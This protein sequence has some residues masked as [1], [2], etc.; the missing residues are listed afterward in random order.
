[1]LVVGTD[2][3]NR[4][5]LEQ[6]SDVAKE[7]G[8]QW[9]QDRFTQE[10]SGAG[11]DDHQGLVGGLKQR[12][13]EWGEVDGASLLLNL[14][15]GT[16]LGF[17]AI[18]S[19]IATL[20]V[21]ESSRIPPI[22]N[23]HSIT[24]RLVQDNSNGNGLA[25]VSNPF[26]SRYQDPVSKEVKEGTFAYK[27]EFRLQTQVGSSHH[28]LHLYV[29][30]RRY[31]D[32]PIVDVN[33]RRDVSVSVG[34]E[35]PRLTGWCHSST[36]VTLPLTGGPKNPRWLDDPALLLSAVQARRLVSPDIGRAHV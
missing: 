23:G 3:S 22:I 17:H 8:N 33:W 6:I 4:P 20:L 11:R 32:A 18:P 25:V 15:T 16:R 13:Q 1:M 12:G 2:V 34:I 28:W 35:Q 29:R 5:T 26:T 9:A 31:V 7:W 30:C 14:N 36:L 10:I 27:L 19:I 24:W 21:Q